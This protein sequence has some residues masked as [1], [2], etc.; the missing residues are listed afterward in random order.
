M[1]V[2]TASRSSAAGPRSSRASC[3]EGRARVRQPGRHPALHRRVL[4]PRAS[5]KRRGDLARRRRSPQLR[6]AGRARQARQPRRQRPARRQHRRLAVA[7][8]L[9]P[10]RLRHPHRAA[11]RRRAGAVPH[12]RRA[13]PGLPLPRDRSARRST[14]AHQDARAHGHRREAPP[15]GRPHQDAHR[16]GQ[17]VELRVSTLPT[18][19]GEK[20]VMRI[21]DPECW[22]GLRE[23]GFS[24]EDT[25]RW[26]EADREPER[27]H[28]GHR[29]RPARARRRR[30]TR[31]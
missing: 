12:R 31:R 2:A 26:A 24:A 13:A 23:L 19:F 15:A 28:P 14:V 17:E 5:M 18:A 8:R 16:N 11:P 21:F 29:A 25:A 20:I 4:H 27:D 22:S 1:R 6:A 10:A 30:S 9:R 3:A 7:V